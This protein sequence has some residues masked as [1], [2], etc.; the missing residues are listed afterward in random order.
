MIPRMTM[1]TTGTGEPF[2]KLPVLQSTT[3]GHGFIPPVVSHQLSSGMIMYVV[4]HHRLP[5][6]SL[7]LLIK[8]GAETDPR[9]KEGISNLTMDGLLLGTGKRS[10]DEIAL[11]LDSLG[12]PVISAAGWDAGWINALA[13]SGDLE[14]LMEIVRDIVFEPIFP[15][16]AF[17]LLK[18]RRLGALKNKQQDLARVAEEAFE[19]VLFK[20]APYGHPVDGTIFSVESISVDDVRSHYF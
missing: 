20:D 3:G 18:E 8:N 13:L 11:V 15:S 9:G 17:R 16:D 7:L 19:T 12:A 1:E 6:V 5:V 14:T 4:E 10:E 2:C